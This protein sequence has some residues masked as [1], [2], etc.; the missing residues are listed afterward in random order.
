MIAVDAGK[1]RVEVYLNKNT[2]VKQSYYD[3]NDLLKLHSFDLQSLGF[4]I[5]PRDEVMPPSYIEAY[6][7]K[8]APTLGFAS[9]MIVLNDLS[10]VSSG[11]KLPA[12]LALSI[13]DRGYLYVDLLIRD[14]V[15]VY[16]LDGF[17]VSY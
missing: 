9:A 7:R 14:A 11:D 10:R 4:K 12:S 5:T 2:Y 8:N 16:R 1:S 3:D 17:T 13:D 6:K 15:L